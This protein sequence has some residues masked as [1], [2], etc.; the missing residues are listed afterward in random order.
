MRRKA[1]EGKLIAK[2]YYYYLGE[3]NLWNFKNNNNEV[4]KFFSIP[5][6]SSVVLGRISG[7]RRINILLA[8]Q[9]ARLARPR[10]PCFT[11]IPRYADHGQLAARSTVGRLTL[12]LARFISFENHVGTSQIEPGTLGCTIV[13][14]SQPV[15][16]P[17]CPRCLLTH[18]YG[19]RAIGPG[20][21]ANSVE[22]V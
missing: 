7:R 17:R 13:Q 4:I 8:T 2:Y 20:D 15:D 11:C 18:K 19:R 6:I 9:H 1:G 5:S 22:S 3:I 21:V 16:K 10:F 14:I 12:L